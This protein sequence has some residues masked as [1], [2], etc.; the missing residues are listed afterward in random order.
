VQFIHCSLDLALNLWCDFSGHDLPELCLDDLADLVTSHILAFLLIFVRLPVL[1][2]VQSHDRLLNLGKQI[3][4]E[5]LLQHFLLLLQKWSDSV[6][7]LLLDHLRHGLLHSFS[8]SLLNRYLQV[9]LG[10]D[11]LLQRVQLH[12]EVCE[13]LREFLEV[14]K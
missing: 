6:F 3:L 7:D 11:L 14:L 10:L 4:P 8:N 13:L 5:L 2:T 12:V 9:F 1:L